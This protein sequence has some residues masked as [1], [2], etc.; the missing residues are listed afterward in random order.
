MRYLQKHV[1]YILFFLLPFCIV[2]EVS[3]NSSLKIQIPHKVQQGTAILVS[4]ISP[5]PESNAIFLWLNKSITVPFKKKGRYWEA[6]TLLPITV[7]MTKSEILAVRTNN[8]YIQQ[9]IHVEPVHWP[10][11][12]ISLGKKKQKFVTP[13]KKLVARLEHERKMIQEALSNISCKQ[14]WSKPFVRPVKGI[15]TSPFGGQRIFNGKPCSYHQGVDLRGAIGTPIKAMAA[16]KPI[17]TLNNG[18]TKSVF[19]GKNMIL[20]PYE[21][22]NKI[23]KSIK[24]NVLLLKNNKVFSEKLSQESKKY[25]DENLMSWNERIDF[26]INQILL[27]CGESDEK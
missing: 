25:A 21:N 10:K 2:T 19:N 7:D 8:N 11:Q 20:L 3:A 9:T 15:I 14:Y 24:E 27:L 23:V 5:I 22:E 16:G 12:Y 26:E 1:Y 17:I 18:N 4:V 13:S 6:Q